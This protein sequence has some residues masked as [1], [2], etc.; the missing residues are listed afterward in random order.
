M[1]KRFFENTVN[2]LYTLQNTENY[3]NSIF[4]A[5]PTYRI[6]DEEN[7]NKRSWRKDA[8]DIFES[9]NFEGTLIIPEWIDDRKPEEWTYSKQVKWEVENLDKC[10]I[11]LFWIPRNLKELPAFTTNVEFGYYLDNPKSIAGSP[12]NAEKNEYLIE[13]FNMIGKT[14]SDNLEDLCKHAIN[15]VKLRTNKYK[16]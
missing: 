9:L 8:I 3:E 2:R 15:L 14:W 13:R 4:L 5:G 1:Y 10:V 11:I 6:K 12:M 16:V 7:L